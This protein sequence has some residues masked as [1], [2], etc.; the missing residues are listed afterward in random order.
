MTIN[1]F[2][3]KALDNKSIAEVNN[4]IIKLQPIVRRFA[5]YQFGKREDKISFYN[6]AYKY[7]GFILSFL[8]D[9]GDFQEG[10][11]FHLFDL[12]IDNFYYS[13]N[14]IMEVENEINEKLKYIFKLFYYFGETQHR[15][16]LIKKLDKMVWLF[17]GES[18]FIVEIIII[19]LKYYEGYFSSSYEQIMDLVSFKI[20]PYL[21]NNEDELMI[22]I[23]MTAL[24]I[25]D[26]EGK[27]YEVLKCLYDTKSFDFVNY[28]ALL[29]R[30]GLYQEL[31]SIMNED[32]D[33]KG[34]FK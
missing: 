32:A 25:Y 6:K 23:G 14:Y 19:S 2:D 33:C 15:L 11:A 34:F 3:I 16:Q 7:N 26:M 9:L 28:D 1:N 5:E 21:L 17:E 30:L 12:N 8:D 24:S 13:L 20:I 4:G 22:G 10:K 18:R 27:T 31:E 29:F